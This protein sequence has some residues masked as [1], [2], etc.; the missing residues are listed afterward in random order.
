M[1]VKFILTLSEYYRTFI[2]SDCDSC[3][4]RYS[5]GGVKMLNKN[6]KR[7][8]EEYEISAKRLAEFMQVNEQDI[9]DWEEGVKEPS[10]QQIHELADL[11]DISYNELL[12]EPVKK[13]S[14][15]SYAKPKNK[16]KT[17]TKKKHKTKHRTKKTKEKTVE[18][19]RNWPWIV[20]MLIILCVGS[21]CGYLYWKYGDEYSLVHNHNYTID[22]MT[23]TFTNENTYEH[24]AS[25]LTLQSGGSYTL[26]YN[27]CSVDTSLTGT[28]SIEK[29]TV[30]LHAQNGEEYTLHINSDNQLKYTSSNLGCSIQKNDVFIR[31]N[32]TDLQE[33]KED[34]DVNSTED[35]MDATSYITTGKWSNSN[36]VLSITQ[37]NN[38]SAVFTLEAMDENDTQHLAKLNSIQASRNGNTLTFTFQDDGYGNAGEGTI[39]FDA[40]Q[41]IF[42]ITKTSVNEH[43]EWAIPE[44][45]TLSPTS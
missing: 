44:S 13:S 35:A 16:K 36:I 43:A 29:T 18:K 28:W 40:S 23:G 26:S 31:G 9:H 8:R 24:T 33:N 27:T 32:K 17:K 1:H 3:H 42:H 19:K 22:E 15:E 6:L 37:L 11:F 14:D 41:A 20:F 2:D 34:R 38:Q 5:L 21:V 45:G 12:A 39:V 7:L 30:T 25:S 10:L 4:N